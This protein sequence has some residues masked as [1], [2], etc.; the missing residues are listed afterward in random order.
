M[1]GYATAADDG[2]VEKPVGVGVDFMTFTRHHSHAGIMSGLPFVSSRAPLNTTAPSVRLRRILLEA[3]LHH[4]DT[5]FVTHDLMHFDGSNVRPSNILTSERTVKSHAA[6]FETRRA[7]ADSTGGGGYIEGFAFWRSIRNRR[8]VH[9]ISTASTP[10]QRD[11]AART[12]LSRSTDVLMSGCS[13][14]GIRRQ[15]RRR[16]RSAVHPVHR[17]CHISS[18]ALGCSRIGRSFERRRRRGG[19]GRVR[20]SAKRSI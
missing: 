9:C 17:S 6:H 14:R 13:A 11:D 18:S 10:Q 8:Q 4:A 20:R 3:D 7:R 16:A 15:R 19:R 1:F 12:S 2:R 5:A